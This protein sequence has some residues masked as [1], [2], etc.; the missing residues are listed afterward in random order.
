MADSTMG[1]MV[2]LI[3]QI[4]IYHPNLE[5]AVPMYNK[6]QIKKE[7]QKKNEGKPLT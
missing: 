3:K 4:I 5:L 6:V 7:T 1:L 2:R